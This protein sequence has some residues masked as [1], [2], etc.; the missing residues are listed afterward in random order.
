VVVENMFY[1]VT[2]DILKQIFARYGQV[3]KII[4]FSKNN[5]FQALIQY[6]DPISAQTA[7][8]SLNGQSIYHG[9]CTLR[10]DYSKLHTLNVR[11][12][13]EKSR[14][15]TDS[16]LPSG[17]ISPVSFGAPPVAYSPGNIQLTPAYTTTVNIP[18]IGP[19]IAYCTATPTT[20]LGAIQY[21][22]VGVAPQTCMPAAQTVGMKL[23][24][25]S[26]LLV[27]NLHEELVTPDALFT[28]FGV[29]GDVLR[30]KIMFNKKDNALVQFVD[31]TQAQIALTHLD[32]VVL[33][34]KS[35]KVAPSK[36]SAVQM[37]KEGQPD[38]GLTKDYTNS[39]LHRFKK[40]NSKNY[41]NIY[42]PSATLHLSNIPPTTTEEQLV[43]MFAQYGNVLA[44]KF[45]ETDHKMALIQM[46]SV[47][48]A[49]VGLINLHNHQLAETS[50]LRVSFSKSTI[51]STPLPPSIDLQEPTK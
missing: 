41:N 50:H 17:D 16:T 22:T 26:V 24:W 10:V 47:E 4:T 45:F 20:A 23:S 32:K 12:N 37:P 28:L 1:P 39:P 44:F 34:G 3:L 38:S 48:E 42:A 29:Y 15:Y 43:Q 33:W 9:C 46:E 2:L 14:D 11:Y 27:T 8:T 13:N 30:V 31:G 25:N 5:A 6:S 35:I 40:P 49:V 18:G 21:G 19:A 51:G 7:K 36:H